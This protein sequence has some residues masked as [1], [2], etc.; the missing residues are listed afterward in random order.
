MKTKKINKKLGGH[1]K[2]FWNSNMKSMHEFSRKLLKES[3]YCLDITN[4]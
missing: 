3:M 2:P 4:L 1:H